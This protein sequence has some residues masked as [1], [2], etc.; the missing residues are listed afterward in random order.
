MSQALEEDLADLRER[1]D[2]TNSLQEQLAQQRRHI[3]GLEADK[4]QLQ[5][6]LEQTKGKV[7]HLEF[8]LHGEMRMILLQETTTDF[9]GAHTLPSALHPATSSLCCMVT[10]FWHA[11]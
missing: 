1:E 9:S 5:Q 7:S 4:Q 11:W 8:D 2:I 10:V 3:A 6:E